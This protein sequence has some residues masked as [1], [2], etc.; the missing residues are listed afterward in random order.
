MTGTADNKILESYLTGGSFNCK[1]Y[2][3]KI[4]EENWRNWN[5]SKEYCG[6]NTSV[7]NKKI[8]IGRVR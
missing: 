4:W 3:I 2:W 8:I 7:K 6:R 5:T 1:K